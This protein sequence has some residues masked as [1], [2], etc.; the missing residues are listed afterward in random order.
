MHVLVYQATCV[1]VEELLPPSL[2]MHHGLPLRLS[3][4]FLGSVLGWIHYSNLPL[5][6]QSCRYVKRERNNTQVQTRVCKVR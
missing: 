2:L 3:V 5:C 6:L 1:L 4:S